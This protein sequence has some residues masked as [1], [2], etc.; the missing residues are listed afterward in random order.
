MFDCDN[1]LVRE[2]LPD[3]LNARLPEAG[4]EQVE[5]HVP[6]CAA[7]R[8]E[9]ETLRVAKT[10][11]SATR[12]RAVNTAAIVAALPRARQRR[13]AWS[14]LVWRVAALLT[15]AAIGGT[16]WRAT[17]GKRVIAWTPDT[18]VVAPA[19][20][21]L[22]GDSQA[23]PPIAPSAPQ[24]LTLGA[25]ESELADDDL[26]TLISALETLEVGP[27]AE[28]DSGVFRITTPRTSGGA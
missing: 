27:A 14:P 5:A 20:V 10:V 8:A 21:P 17:L 15:V 28:P 19:R 22:G 2:L 11:L 24:R 9:L 25:G 6:T 26:K 23:T 13:P 4:R 3:Y 7:C 18:A 1:V 16:A 12:V